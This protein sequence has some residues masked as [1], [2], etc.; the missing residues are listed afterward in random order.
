MGFGK[1]HSFGGPQNGGFGPSGS[2]MSATKRPFDDFGGGLSEKRGRGG[3]F[4]GR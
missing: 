2:R 1:T 4:G 3:G